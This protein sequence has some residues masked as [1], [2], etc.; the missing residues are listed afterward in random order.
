MRP[1]AL[2]IVCNQL[3]LF[4]P[5][6]PLRWTGADRGRERMMAVLARLLRRAS[7]AFCCFPLDST[8]GPRR[9][10]SIRCTEKTEKYGCRIK[11]IRLE[12][13]TQPKLLSLI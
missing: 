6:T 2:R 13:Q 12:Y 10:H 11:A 5:T 7:G 9:K 3:R 8:R 4:L 1:K